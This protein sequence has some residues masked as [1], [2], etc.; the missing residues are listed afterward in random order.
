MA[1]NCGRESVVG[2]RQ[3]GQDLLHAGDAAAADIGLAEQ[4]VGDDAE[5]RQD[6]DDHDPGDARRRVAVRA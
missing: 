5:R 2:R 6:Q 3:L 4:D 1:S